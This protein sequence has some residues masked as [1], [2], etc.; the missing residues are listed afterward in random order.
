[1]RGRQVDNAVDEVLPHERVMQRPNGFH[2]FWCDVCDTWILC[3][4]PLCLE[5]KDRHARLS[6][7]V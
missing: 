4:W 6:H 2:Y 7:H 3:S 5:V 1:M